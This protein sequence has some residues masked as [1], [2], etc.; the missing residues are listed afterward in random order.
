MIGGHAAD[1]G[2]GHDPS[3]IHP[4]GLLTI[5]AQPTM[6]QAHVNAN[7]RCSYTGIFRCIVQESLQL[8]QASCF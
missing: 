1:L 3:P 7:M 8:V 5:I 6:E 4:K 2:I